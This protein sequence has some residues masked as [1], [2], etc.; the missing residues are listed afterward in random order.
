MSS[1]DMSEENTNT[2]SSENNIESLLSDISISLLWVFNILGLL[3]LN[4]KNSQ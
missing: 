4:K 3:L 2:E 1:V